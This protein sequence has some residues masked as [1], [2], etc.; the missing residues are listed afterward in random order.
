MSPRRKN[1]L[2][3]QR[4]QAFLAADD[5]LTLVL[6][7]HLSLEALLVHWL[8]FHRPPELTNLDDLRFPARVDMMVAMGKLPIESRAAWLAMNA[9]RNDFAHE[10]DA[11]LDLTIARR[12]VDAM[13][14]DW[15]APTRERGET[16]QAYARRIVAEV[17]ERLWTQGVHRFFKEIMP[18][19]TIPAILPTET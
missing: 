2:S 19:D 11:T 3:A 5:D 7:G 9:I 6:R 4:L 12:L 1:P 10:V 18:G 8:D 16:D 17:I 14:T 13:P 15:E